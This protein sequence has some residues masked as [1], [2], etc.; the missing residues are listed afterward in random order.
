MAGRPASQLSI[1]TVVLIPLSIFLL[2]PSLHFKFSPMLIT[3]TNYVGSLE[4]GAR[5][6]ACTLTVSRYQLDSPDPQRVR[7]LEANLERADADYQ[8]AF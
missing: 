3:I 6:I 8:D 4:L 1:K 5:A 2:H 7:G